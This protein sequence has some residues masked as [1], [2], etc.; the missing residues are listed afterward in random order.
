M[1]GTIKVVPTINTF[2]LH[3]KGANAKIRQVPLIKA[4]NVEK[5]I[6]FANTIFNIFDYFPEIKKKM[7]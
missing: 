4:L 1:Q 3:I 7:P 5:I 6:V 2:E